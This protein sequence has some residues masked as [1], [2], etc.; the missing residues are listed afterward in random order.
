MNKAS[1]AFFLFSMCV[2]LHSCNSE[3]NGQNVYFTTLPVIRVNV[4]ETFEVNKTHAIGVTYLKPDT[5][6]SFEGF[7]VAITRETGRDIAVI[8]SVITND[9]ACAQV[10]EEAVALFQFTVNFTGKYLFRFYSGQDR[11][12]NPVYLEYT[13]PM[14]TGQ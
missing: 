11:S 2:L 5:C 1:M 12:G 7:D 4:P 3:D 6:T 8:G 9:V 10:V 13:V 14:D